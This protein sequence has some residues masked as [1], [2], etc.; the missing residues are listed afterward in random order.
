MS[1]KQEE[2]DEVGEL[3][4]AQTVKRLRGCGTTAGEPLTSV[5][6]GGVNM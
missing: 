1:R 3:G 4:W 2:Q 6:C 5:E